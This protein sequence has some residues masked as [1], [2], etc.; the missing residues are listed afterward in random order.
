[1]FGY[2]SVC[3]QLVQVLLSNDSLIKSKTGNKGGVLFLASASNMTQL[4]DHIRPQTNTYYIHSCTRYSVCRDP[5]GFTSRKCLVSLSPSHSSS[6]CVFSSPTHHLSCSSLKSPRRETFNTP[7]AR[8]KTSCSRGPVLH[9]CSQSAQLHVYNPFFKLSYV[10]CLIHSLHAS[11]LGHD[12][13]YMMMM[14][15]VF[16]IF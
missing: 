2:C 10:S 3:S 13:K 16:S 15:A 9:S 4:M 14:L 6:S 11:C 12:I 8:P 1:M 7:P 5:E